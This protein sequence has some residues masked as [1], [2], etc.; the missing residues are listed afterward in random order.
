MTSSGLVFYHGTDARIARL[1][2]EEREAIKT[3][4]VRFLDDIYRVFKPYMSPE[5][6]Q[7]FEGRRQFHEKLEIFKP[8]M[9]FGRDE[10]I[11]WHFCEALILNRGRVTGSTAWHY[12]CTYLTKSRDQAIG[13]ANRSYMF[14]EIG[15]MTFFLYSALH[16]MMSKTRIG[17]S[18]VLDEI[19]R[20]A[21]DK[22]IKEAF[23]MVKTF[24]IDA[25]TQRSLD[26]VMDFSRAPGEP[27]I[28]EI[29]GLEYSDLQDDSGKPVTKRYIEFGNV[30]RC[31]HELFL[32]PSSA[33]ELTEE[34]KGIHGVR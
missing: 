28:F 10:D 9:D 4:C 7:E 30:Y 23:R 2:K 12:D 15:M 6:F 21:T 34:E 18:K 14:G 3:G 33:I 13:Y 16:L 29:R 26:Y 25:D 1:S 19:R 11:Y 8:F 20:F 22:D 31:P 27:V 17:R 24:P 32:D 5:S